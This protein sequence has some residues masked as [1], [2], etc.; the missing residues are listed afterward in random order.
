MTALERVGLDQ[1]GQKRMNRKSQ[2]RKDKI[3]NQKGGRGQKER[4][5]FFRM[6]RQGGLG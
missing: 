1:K 4:G 6:A 5:R 2:A 3:K